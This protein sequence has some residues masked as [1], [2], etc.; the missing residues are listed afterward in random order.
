MHIV[1]TIA[2]R[3]R[4]RQAGTFFDSV[5]RMG[6][7]GEMALI[8]PERDMHMNCTLITLPLDFDTEK[9]KDARWLQARLDEPF[10]EGDK[11]LF[12]DSDCEVLHEDLFRLFDTAELAVSVRE[13]A[14]D[15]QMRKLERHTGIH[16]YPRIIITP[17]L[18]TVNEVIREFFRRFREAREM[19]KKLDA[20]TML[21]YSYAWY[22]TPGIAEMHS[23]IPRK[24]CVYPTWDGA[25][26]R[27]HFS[28]KR[29]APWIVHYSG[30]I[31]RYMWEENYDIQLSA[32][33][34]IW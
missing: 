30:K 10:E 16:A 26:H 25:K 19:S 20:G 33:R 6:W 15:D 13:D 7:R 34:R 21:A 24:R 17:F 14:E 12:C 2:D 32:D 23:I 11:I 3:N 5:R 8:T 22:T 9:F 27:I 29:S 31:G 4:E 1:C 18:F 28:E